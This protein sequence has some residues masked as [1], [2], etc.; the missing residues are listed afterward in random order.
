MVRAA[1]EGLKIFM[2]AKNAGK[3]KDLEEEDK[4][5]KQTQ[6]MIEKQQ[7]LAKRMKEAASPT[8][9]QA[10]LQRHAL[11]IQAKLLEI[12]QNKDL[13][14]QTENELQNTSAK[15]EGVERKLL[16]IHHDS[17]EMKKSEMMEHSIVAVQAN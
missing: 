1:K 15:V 6:D 3:L 13:T 11:Q 17:L 16:Q 9:Q 2:E 5:E 8:D 12:L 10:D 7:E 14:L 4:Q